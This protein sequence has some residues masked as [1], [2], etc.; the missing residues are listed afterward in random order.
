MWIHHIVTEI[1]LNQYHF[2]ELTFYLKFASNIACGL[3]KYHTIFD[4]SKKKIFEKDSGE[5]EDND[6][7]D[8]LS[9][10][11]E[12]TKK[13]STGL[14]NGSSFSEQAIKFCFSENVNFL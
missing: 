8:D 9:R 12:E 6:H 13:E 7:K 1:F 4:G 3:A 2:I 11:K 10:L 5:D 14:H